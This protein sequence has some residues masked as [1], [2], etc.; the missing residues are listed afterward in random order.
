M[1]KSKEGQ[2]PKQATQVQPNPAPA[3]KY[4]YLNDGIMKNDHPIDIILVGAGATGSSFAH[5]LA[6]LQIIMEKMN[7]FFNVT[8][9]DMGEVKENN[10]GKQSFTP[11]AQGINKASAVVMQINRFY[12]LIWTAR[13]ADA[14]KTDVGCADILIS[15]VDTVKARKAISNKSVYWLDMGNM[16]HHGQVILGYKGEKKEDNLPS[17]LDLYPKMKEDNDEPS[18]SVFE[19]IAKQSLFVNDMAAVLGGILLSDLLL[20]KQIDYSG[21]FFN[22]NNCMI[23]KL[24]IK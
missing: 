11:V 9:I 14:I 10:I 22:I 8:V 4:H 23:T 1:A 20:K 6:R 5:H 19:S 21:Y 18:C 2:K 12:G 17:I 24:K 13:N 7:I 15:A 16:R 3:N